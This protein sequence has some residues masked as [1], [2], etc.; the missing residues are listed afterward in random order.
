MPRPRRTRWTPIYIS[1]NQSQMACRA[2]LTSFFALRPAGTMYKTTATIAISGSEQ[3]KV[4]NPS[5]PSQIVDCGTLTG[6]G[7]PSG[8][9]YYCN[10]SGGGALIVMSINPA[11]GQPME[12]GYPISYGAGSSATSIAS[13]LQTEI[14]ATSSTSGISA[15]L[16]GSSLSL[17]INQVFPTAMTYQI[18]GQMTASGAFPSPSF[19]TALTVPP[20]TTT[21]GPAAA[22]Y[23]SGTIAATVDGVTAS[24]PWGST[25]T[26]ITV[27]QGLANALNQKDAGV[28]TATPSNGTITLT[29]VAPGPATYSVS[30]TT[31]FSNA[32]FV[33]SF[34]PTVPK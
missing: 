18:V 29:S 22:V 6:Q 15:V 33:A 26:Y 19:T 23:D 10:D 28:F 30:S 24:Y 21:V 2:P 17:T 4:V 27:A 14:N 31:T 12:T 11:N 32:F 34:F 25:D 3:S 1:V 8:T 9:T 20:V 16:N 13:A 5:V 7:S